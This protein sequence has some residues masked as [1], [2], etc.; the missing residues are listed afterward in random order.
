ML[1]LDVDGTLVAG[2]DDVPPRVRDAL[3]RAHGEG[4]HVV[5]ATGRRWRRTRSVV[6]VLGLPAPAV[7]L[8]GAI[9]KDERGQT[10]HTEGYTPEAFRAVAQIVRSHGQTVIIQRDE[11]QGGG[12]FAI[13]QSSAWGGPTQRYFERN[14]AFAEIAPRLC[15]QRREDALGVIAFGQRE[16]LD[17]AAAEIEARY[18]GAYHPH[19]MDARMEGAFCLQVCTAR[20]NK[21]GALQPVAARAGVPSAAI[22]AVGDDVNDLTM[23]RGAGYGVAMGNATPE[24]RRAADWVTAPQ[25]EDGLVHVVDRVLG[26]NPESPPA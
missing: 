11:G 24:V 20:A 21:W 2:E 19:V 25:H 22:C 10:L 1:A 5:I 18:P 16:P 15:E 4:L 6:A 9:V 12:D 7:C 8:G 17:A 14:R 23:I 3:H 13:D 26:Q